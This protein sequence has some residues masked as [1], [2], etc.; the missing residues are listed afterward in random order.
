M[1][2]K[3]TER[4]MWE[5]EAWSHIV[6]VD[7]QEGQVINYLMIFARLA[8]ELCDKAKIDATKAGHGQYFAASR[9]SVEFFDRHEVT[10]RSIYLKNRGRTLV[11]SKAS[12]YKNSELVLDRKISLAKM[13]SAVIAARDKKQNVLYKNFESVFLKSKKG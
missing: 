6:E 1:L 9:Y 12:G 4:N 10:D 5:H 7:K 3:I 8:N 2:L 11:V 13:K